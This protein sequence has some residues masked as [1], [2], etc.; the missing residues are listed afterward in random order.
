LSLRKIPCF[1][2]LRDTAN[3]KREDVEDVMHQVRT[4]EVF[5]EGSLKLLRIN[6]PKK[7]LGLLLNINGWKEIPS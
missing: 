6:D 3:L 7:V 4:G 2:E 1:D 5:S